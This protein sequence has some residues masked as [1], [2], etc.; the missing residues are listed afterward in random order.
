MEV[1]LSSDDNFVVL[2]ITD[3][4]LIFVGV[5]EIDGNVS[6]GDTGLSVLIDEFS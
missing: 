1:N 6:F 4:T 3:R 2:L 5:V